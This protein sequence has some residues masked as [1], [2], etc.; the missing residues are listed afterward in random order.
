MMPSKSFIPG[1]DAS[2]EFSIATM[3]QKLAARGY[4][5]EDSSWLNLA[6]NLGDERS[7][8]EILGLAVPVGTVWKELRIGELK[9]L[10][11]LAIGDTEATRE[12]CD[13][14]HHYR[15]MK[16]G[17][18][19]VY[20]WIEALLNLDTPAEFR[21]S[22]AL[23]YGEEAL[24]QAEA[25]LDGKE[26]FFGLPTLG[27]DMEGSPIHGKLPAAYDTLFVPMNKH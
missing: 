8:W 16:H 22:L 13:W 23:L 4:F 12:S 10:L 25:L 14:I 24:R 6:V 9:T 18:W 1:K 20:R 26:R 21:H 17:R 11:E 2:L 15:Q 7:L 19:L 3:Q 5:L 27:P